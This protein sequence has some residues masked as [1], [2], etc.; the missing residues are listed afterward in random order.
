[1]PP[2]AARAKKQWSRSKTLWRN[3][4]FSHYR[5][6]SIGELAAEVGYAKST[7]HSY[8]W[9]MDRRGLLSYNG[10]TAETAVTRKAN[11]E[12]VLTPVL[13]G[14]SCGQPE[15]VE[16]D[17]EAYVVLPTALF[18]SGELFLLRA[19]TSKDGKNR[20]EYHYDHNGL[21]TGKTMYSK[22]TYTTVM[23]DESGNDVTVSKEQFVKAATIEYI[24][25]DGILVGYKTTAFDAVKMKTTI[26]FLMNLGISKLR[27]ITLFL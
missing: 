14:I 4:Y 17:F 26:M 13:G 25:S 22:E 24:W 23:Q 11:A 20:Y 19:A 5:S 27:Q 6:P 1:M 9:E 12:V 8:L 18:G 10:K 2:C 21:R 16:E 7:V 15:Y 3:F